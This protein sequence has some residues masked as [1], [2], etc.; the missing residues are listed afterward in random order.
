MTDEFADVESR[1]GRYQPSRPSEDARRRMEALFHPGSATT[2]RRWRLVAAGITLPL[3]ALVAWW[4][5]R[6]AQEPMQAVAIPDE[7]AKTFSAIPREPM[8]PFD[9]HAAVVVMLFNDWQCPPCA[10][11]YAELQR[12]VATHNRA[13]GGRVVLVTRDWPF[14]QKCNSESPGEMHRL[15]CELAVAVRIARRH[16]RE[17]TRVDWIRSR[18][19]QFDDPSAG[20]AIN[21]ALRRLLGRIDLQAEQVEAL[22]AIEQDVVDGSRLQVNRTPTVFV[23]GHRLTPSK[24]QDIDWAIRLELARLGK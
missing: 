14:N 4:A 8:P 2:P 6:P 20:D 3:I 1:L 22:T 23:N 11:F 21:D 7:F 12:I 10:D 19:N 15:A 9:G 16:G 17:S 24:P 13:G 5:L 18:R